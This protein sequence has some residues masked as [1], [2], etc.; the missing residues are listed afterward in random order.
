MF[1]PKSETSEPGA[2]CGQPLAESTIP[3][4]VKTGPAGVI[5]KDSGF[6]RPAEVVTDKATEPGWEIRLAA[7]AADNW[8]ELTQVV[9]RVWPFHRTLE[10]GINPLPLTV[11]VNAALPTVTDCGERAD[12]TGA[13]AVRVKMSAFDEDPPGF[14]TAIEFEPGTPARL[15]GTDAVN[16]EAEANTVGNGPPFQ[17]TTEFAKKLDPVTVRARLEVPAAA[18]AGFSPVIDGPITPKARPLDLAPPALT[19]VIATVPGVASRLAGTV[20]VNE[21]PLTTFVVRDVSFQ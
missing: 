18:D 8:L 4:A 11:K 15:A 13:V 19:T 3:A 20:A 21:P 9:G 14:D 2:I 10:P 6:E 1:A 16:W 12:N 7:T 17:R 5:E